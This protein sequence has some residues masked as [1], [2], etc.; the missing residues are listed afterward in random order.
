MAILPT[1]QT[2]RTRVMQ[3]INA[4]IESAQKKCDVEHAELDKQH[5]KDRDTLDAKLFQDKQDVTDRLVNE[6]IGKIM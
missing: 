6:I 4:R 1:K 3:S 2:I 5:Q